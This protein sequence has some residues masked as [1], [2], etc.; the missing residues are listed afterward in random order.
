MPAQIS[1]ASYAK[2]FGPTVGDKV[3]LA[4]TELF[5]EVENDFTCYG[6]EVKFGGGKVIRDGM[7]QSQLS[8]AQGAVD[9]VITNAVILDHTG[10]YKADVGLR[11]GR[12][13]AIGKSGNPDTQPG[14]TI[15]IGPGTEVIAG[16]GKILT[17]GGIDTHIHFIS[18][19]QVDEALNSGVTC[20]VGGGTGPAHG[21]LATTCSPGPWNIARI[22]QAFDGLPMNIG[23]FGKGN[24]SLPGALE[25]MVLAGACGLKLHEDWGTT[26]AA[27]DTCLSV[28]DAHDVQVTIHTDTLN[29]GG[30]VEDTVGAFKGRTIH[31]FHTEG[32]GGGHA[33]DIIKVCQYPNVIPA[34]TNPTRPYTVNT[35]SEHLDMLMVCHHL[36]PSI[37]E[38][39]AFAE[40]R[41]RKET[42]A[43]E[44]ILHDLGAFSVISSD[45]Q[46]MGRVGEM[47]I[48][49]WQTADK[50]KRQRGSLP[51]E[52]GNND[53]FRARRYIAKYTINPA[54]AHG[55]SR[56][57]GSIEVGKRAD[58]VL[59]NPA[60]FGVKPDMVLLGGWIATAPMGDPNGSI[61]T[62]QPSHFRPMFG[63]YGKALT[64]SSITFVSKAG[65]EGG[66]RD[67]IGVAKEMVAVE[68]TRGGIGKRS[69]ILNDA[70]PEI[71][72]DPE[73]YEVRADGELLTCEPAT[74]L[75]MAQRYFLF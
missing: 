74:V 38:D 65:L 45:S 61:P 26:P 27:I 34:S 46:A 71:D 66:L 21:T 70:M 75:P 51:G 64:H 40:S 56:E 4:D 5:I 39:I 44:D 15:I 36:S 7:G 68:N 63:A 69:M 72:V 1:R 60:F 19:Q 10:I 22:I 57:I 14:V 23:V 43:A 49:T 11:D 58:L 41:I 62:P 13:A 8:R 25:E 30:F 55:M 50:M 33:P 18:P 6:E 67:R 17:A 9:C 73:T 28:A 48:R 29:E 37:P 53:N 52:K 20:M 24:A 35:I 16:E 32:A 47:I 31:S 59:W 12:I 2:M 3:R 42:I 54:I